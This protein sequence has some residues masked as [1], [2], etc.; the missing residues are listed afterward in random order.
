MYFSDRVCFGRDKFL[1][2]I[3]VDARLDNA[4]ARAMIAKAVIGIRRSR[5]L[6]GD[7][8]CP[9]INDVRVNDLAAPTAFNSMSHFWHMQFL[10]L[11]SWRYTR[12]QLSVLWHLVF[13][14]VCL[15]A[16]RIGFKSFNALILFI[17]DF[18]QRFLLIFQSIIE[19]GKKLNSNCQ[20]LPWFRIEKIQFISSWNR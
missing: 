7:Q 6:T 5:N 16:P 13:P 1:I 4:A 14:R 2:D 19:I 3:A 18:K 8:R 12:Y 10:S 11:S 17:K 9:V 15:S 20:N